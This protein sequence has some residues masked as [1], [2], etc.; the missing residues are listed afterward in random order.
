MIVDSLAGLGDRAANKSSKARR[1]I[2]GGLARLHGEKRGKR[3]S[4]ASARPVPSLENIPGVTVALCTS[5]R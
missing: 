5:P 3:H 2:L 4:V 1:D